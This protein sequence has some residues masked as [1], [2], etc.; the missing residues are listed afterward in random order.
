MAG[1]IVVSPIRIVGAGMVGDLP[2]TSASRYDR[3]LQEGLRKRLKIR[4]APRAMTYAIYRLQVDLQADG[5]RHNGGHKGELLSRRFL[6]LFLRV[7]L[8]AGGAEGVSIVGTR[9]GALPQRDKRYRRSAEQRLRF[10]HH[11]VIGLRPQGWHCW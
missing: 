9:V 3:G 7:R 8:G 1:S 10:Y 6:C 2:C 4:V 11:G 5:N